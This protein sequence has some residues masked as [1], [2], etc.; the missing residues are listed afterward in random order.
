[1][2]TKKQS[3]QVSPAASPMVYQHTLAN[4]NNNGEITTQFANYIGIFEDWEIKFLI[5]QMRKH[6]EHIPEVKSPF[7]ANQ[8]P[9]VQTGVVLHLLTIIGA[10]PGVPVGEVGC[11]AASCML[12]KL[13]Q[14]IEAK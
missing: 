13:L 11:A 2:S 6:I 14:A 9:E 4:N 5:V 1:M 7:K 8:L 10:T 12:T 3:G